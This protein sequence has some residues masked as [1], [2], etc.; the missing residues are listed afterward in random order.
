M[1]IRCVDEI[2]CVIR[3]NF[4]CFRQCFVINGSLHFTHTVALSFKDYVRAA[5]WQ[6]KEPH[7][8]PQSN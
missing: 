8:H 3:S 1:Y 2:F 7:N 5:W 6:D 4:V